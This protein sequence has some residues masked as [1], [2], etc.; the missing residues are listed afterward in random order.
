MKTIFISLCILC[1]VAITSCIAQN[2]QSDDTLK[3]NRNNLQIFDSFNH[4]GQPGLGFWNG[5]TFVY[6]GEEVIRSKR[7][8]IIEPRFPGGEIALEK[9]IKDTRGKQ[10]IIP[11][12]FNDSHN[13]IFQQ[14]VY[15][16]VDT[17]GSIQDVHIIEYFGTSYCISDVKNIIKKMPK[18]LPAYEIDKNNGKKRTA[19]ML[20]H[21]IVSYKYDCYKRKNKKLKK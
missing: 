15:F 21:I 7:K 10:I 19:K 18:W 3:D 9:F 16:Q 11:N 4:L 17:D 5:D 1:A 6:V 14:Y 12:S 8:Q 13:H 20:T 2:A